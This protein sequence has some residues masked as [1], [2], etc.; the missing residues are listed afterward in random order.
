MILRDRE[1]GGGA[2]RE[3][4]RERGSQAGSSLNAESDIGLKLM[5]REIMTSAKTKSQTLN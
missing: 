1:I 3:R 5:N 2:E 4:E